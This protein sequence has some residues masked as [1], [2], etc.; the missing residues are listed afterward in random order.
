MMNGTSGY[1]PT[2]AG[3]TYIQEQ[4]WNALNVYKQGM[5]GDVDSDGDVDYVDSM[6]TL[7]YY[8]QEIGAEDLDVTVA[9]VDGNGVVNYVDAMLILQHY[10]QEIAVFPAA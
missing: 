7:Q 3:H 4:I 6:L 5:L 1:V 10:T 8:T 9:D 2:D